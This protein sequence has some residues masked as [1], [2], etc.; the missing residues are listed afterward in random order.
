MEWS[1]QSFYRDLF[2][3]FRSIAVQNGLTGESV[4]VSGRPLTNEEAI[5]NPDRKD[6][7]LLTGRERLMEAGFRGFRGQAFTDQPGPFSGTIGSILERMPEDNYGRA[8]FISTL[9]AV[10]ASLGLCGATVHCR[11]NEPEQCAFDIASFIKESHG[12][13]VK[14]ALVGLQLSMVDALAPLFQLR[15]LDLNP[16]KIGTSIS[17]VKIENGES[18]V[19]DVLRWCDIV[20]CTGSTVVNGTITRYLGPETAYFYGTSIA[21]TAALTGLNRLCFKASL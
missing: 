11:D 17:S 19:D 4:V 12:A 1:S 13:D 16:E 3:K 20:L 9:N 2:E 7:P 5:G 15:V 14:I 21:G 10:C 8:V 6:F 18:D